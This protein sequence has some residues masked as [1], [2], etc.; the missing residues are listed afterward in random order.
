MKKLFA[1]IFLL[2]FGMAGLTLAADLDFDVD[3]DNKIDDIFL[4]FSHDITGA[5]ECDGAGAC[6]QAEIEDLSNYN[7][8]DPDYILGDADDDDK[9]DPEAIDLI[10]LAGSMSV[11]DLITLSGRAAGSQHLSTFTGAVIDDN[12]TIKAALQDLETYVESLGGGHDPVTLSTDLN[13]NLLGLSAQQLTIDSQ[14][15]NLVFSGPAS[16][17]SAAPSFRSLVVADIPDISATYEV[18]L[19]N[20]AGL[21]AVL[22]DVSDFHQPGD[23]LRTASGTSLPGSCTVGDFYWDTDADTDGSL[24]FCRATDT[25]KEVDDDG[26]AGSDVLAKV[27]ADETDADY[28]VNQISSTNG[29]INVTESGTGTETLMIDI[30]VTPSAGSPTLEVLYQRAGSGYRC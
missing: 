30:D 17:G 26:G 5:V 14:A 15:A 16:G 11:D 22:S 23:T 12:L 3:N 10:E 21:Y 4:D 9:L 25:W 24:Y 13:S 6:E 2:V 19:N 20:E 18:Q 29:E 27:S 8:I 7:A 28:L 1:L